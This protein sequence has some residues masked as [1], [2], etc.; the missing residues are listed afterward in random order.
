MALIHSWGDLPSL[1]SHLLVA[2]LSNNAALA[3]RFLTHELWGIYLNHNTLVL[4]AICVTLGEKPHLSELYDMQN[5]HIESNYIRYYNKAKSDECT[6]CST[7]LTHCRIATGLSSCFC[8]LDIHKS[9]EN[10][11]FFDLFGR[12]LGPKICAGIVFIPLRVN[13]YIIFHIIINMFD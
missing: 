3:I 2:S 7:C 1:R 5:W 8:H 4:T 11:V 6:A 9:P 12:N 10:K 13:I